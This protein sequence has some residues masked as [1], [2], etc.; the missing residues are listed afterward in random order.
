MQSLIPLFVFAGF[1]TL[2][3]VIWYI[4]TYNSF[5]KYRNR[6]EEAWSGIEVA[7][8]RRF[9]LI[10]N[11][12]QAVKGYGDH[13]SRILTS[14]SAEAIP[15]SNASARTAEESRVTK[16]LSGL[17]ALAEAYP[18]LKA[19]QNFLSLQASLNEIEFDIQKARNR[20]NNEVRRYNTLI[21]SFPARWIAK[22][23]DF[24]K[25]EYFALELATQRE[26]PHVDFDSE[27]Q[28]RKAEKQP[29]NINFPPISD[30]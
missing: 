23:Y 24:R 8:K 16:S 29:A 25:T 12:I 4:K 27:R 17:L 5:I 15:S 13:E 9:N 18:D 7:L 2:V 3:S 1:G 20:L 21:E 6:I 22:K 11:M 14:R 19:S 26:L 28:R 10:P 30:H